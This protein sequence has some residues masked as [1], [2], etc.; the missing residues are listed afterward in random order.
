V[1]NPAFVKP[2]SA[3][4][5]DDARKGAARTKRAPLYPVCV[6]GTAIALPVRTLASIEIDVKLGRRPGWTERLSGVAS[7]HIAEA[8][9]AIDL[10]LTAARKAIANAGLAIDDVDCVIGANAVPFQAI[11]P[12]AVFIH[13]GLGIVRADVPAFDANAT[14]L[15]FLAAVDMA[16]ALIAAKRYRNVLVTSCDLPSRGVSWGDP[17]TATIFGD[18]A[19]AAVLQRS[20]D[21][22][23]GVIAI[24]LETHS[25][26]AHTCEMRAG[27]TGLDPRRD[28]EKFLLGA[29]FEMDGPSAY[30]I[31]SRALP[32]FVDRLL[33]AAGLSLADID[34]VIPH[35]ASAPAMRHARKLLGVPPHKIVDIFA[36]HGNQVS[37]SLPTALHIARERRMVEPGSLALLIG[38]AAGI[39]LGGAVIRC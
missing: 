15:S 35:Q 19:A 18:G 23:Q 37:A 33:F 25:D 20:E 1:L 30:R 5:G 9:T 36:D 32:D 14:C 26:G 6:A 21:D 11:P 3:R 31:A 13:R 2:V 4:R 22:G 38:S 10:S 24:E 34:V 8:E 27:G 16:G 29:H 28:P 7:R 12:T 39:T 17:E